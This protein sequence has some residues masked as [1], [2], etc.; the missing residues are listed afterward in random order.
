MEEML[1]VVGRIP[2]V[3]DITEVVKT[4]KERNYVVGI[5]SNSYQL[6]CQYVQ[7]EIGAD[8]ILAN[9]LEFFEG[10]ATGEVSMP[11]YFFPS[12]ESTCHHVLCKT[13]ALQYA[14]EKYHV[15][16]ENCMAVGDS[17]DDACMVAHAGRGF[18]FCTMDEGLKEAATQIIEKPSF[19]DLLIHWNENPRTTIKI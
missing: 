1:K 2:I 12:P 18:A 16:M 4:L 3:S 19:E 17:L 14:C 9:R 7:H 8:F 15:K 11:S 5:I 13:H 10:I 6:V